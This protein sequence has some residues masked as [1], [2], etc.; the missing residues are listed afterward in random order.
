M[1]SELTEMAG[2]AEAETQAAYAW[3]LDD[4]DDLATQRL[5][6]R[7]ITALALAASLTIIAAAGAVMLFVARDPNQPVAQAPSSPVVVETVARP[8]PTVTVSAPAPPVIS[9]APFLGEWGMHGMS[10]TLAP[11]GSAQYMA[12]LG[13]PLGVTWSATWSPMTSTTVMIVLTAQTESH[14]GA[15]QRGLYTPE[16]LTWIDGHSGQS[17]A[18]TLRGDGYA[19]VQNPSGKLVTLCPDPTNFHDTKGLCGA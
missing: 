11:D 12:W 19:T 10:V 5:T 9:R 4:G 2:V 3:A 16:G 14:G 8:V 18:F 6:P 7:R 1:S 15:A 17:L 13:A